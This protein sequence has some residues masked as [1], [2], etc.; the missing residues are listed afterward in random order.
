VKY[1]FRWNQW[2]EQHVQKHG[3][4]AA[5][6][7]RVIR[8]AGRGYPRKIGDGKYEVIARGQGGRFVRVIFIYS[9]PGVV[10]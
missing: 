1:R 2:N 8:T 5:E 9:P 10:Y 7:E 4:S 3:S 6:A